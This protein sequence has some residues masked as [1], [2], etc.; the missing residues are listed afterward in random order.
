MIYTAERTVYHSDRRM[1]VS[2]VQDR[3]QASSVD[4]LQTGFSASQCMADQ[5][6]TCPPPSACI[7]PVPPSPRHLASQFQT[8]DDS[9][10]G[11]A[12]YTLLSSPSAVHPGRM[13]P[14]SG[15]LHGAYNYGDLP[16]GVEK[17][18]RSKVLPNEV[19]LV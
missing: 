7:E 16:L 4:A 17:A 19:R 6:T 9:P 2:V 11:K 15:Y 14:H 12:Q 10:S 1:F 5:R 13:V 3:L 8:T 18:S